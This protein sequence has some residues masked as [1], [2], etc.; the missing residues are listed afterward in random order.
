MLSRDLLRTSPQAV[1][2][3]L[4][5]RGGDVKLVDKFLAADKLW[6]NELAKLEILQR[7]RNDMSRSGKPS[8]AELKVAKKSYSQLSKKSQV[9]SAAAKKAEDLLLAIPSLVA[10]D[11]PVGAGESANTV[12]KE[13]GKPKL[14]TGKP[15]QQL[16]TELG[17]LDLSTAAEVSG[18]RFR[19]LK[20][21]AASAW[22]ELSRLGFRFAVK[23][24]FQPVI[25]PVIVRSDILTKGGF[26]PEGEE[27]TFKAGDDLYLVGTSEYSLVASVANKVFKKDELPLRLVGFST[28]FRKEAGSY[29]KDVKGMFR[30]HQFDKVEMVSICRQDQSENEH[31]FL[32]EMQERFVQQFK[33]PYQAVLIGSGDLEKKAIKRFDLETWFP[34]QQR[35]RETHSASNCTDYQ[36][37]ALGI[38]YRDQA[39]ETKFAHTL[40]G[41]LVTERLLLAY[42][43]NNQRPDGTVMLPRSLR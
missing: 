20:G 14:M 5:K 27:D 15:H 24:G 9:V 41:T 34:G 8:A 10:P 40:N 12:I 18:A 2:N 13:V 32:L 38:K 31:D 37:R 17:W 36:S 33:L 1:I 6:R 23:H 39:G 22:M 42:I 3:S 35:Y 7:A 19:Y 21:P 25:P 16:M 30:Q 4:V 26:F 43:E 11:V 28:C 29:G